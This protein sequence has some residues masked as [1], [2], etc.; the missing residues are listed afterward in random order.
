MDNHE[1]SEFYIAESV[2]NNWTSSQL[3]RQLKSSLY[4]HLLMSSD[5]ESVLAQLQ[6]TKNCL[7][8]PEKL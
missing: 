2:K 5:K 7:Q 6:K 1:K 8:M 4:E 3:E